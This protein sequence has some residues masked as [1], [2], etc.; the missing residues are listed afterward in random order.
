PLHLQRTRYVPGV[1]G[2]A[3]DALETGMAAAAGGV[4]AVSGRVVAGVAFFFLVTRPLRSNSAVY[5][6]GAVVAVAPRTACRR[7]TR[8]LSHWGSLVPRPWRAALSSAPFPR[9]GASFP[10]P[11]PAAS[12]A[13]FAAAMVAGD[14]ELSRCRLATSVWIVR[15]SS[16]GGKTFIRPGPW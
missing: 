5:R 14:S 6:P 4:T 16:S 11:F 12:A 10:S 3:G 15:A 1:G 7:A 8:C 2:A 13:W 9:S